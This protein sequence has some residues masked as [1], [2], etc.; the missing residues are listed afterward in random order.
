MNHNI[1]GNVCPFVYP[2]VCLSVYM[3]PLYVKLVHQ[4]AVCIHA[5][6]VFGCVFPWQTDDI[7]VE[8][9]MFIYHYTSL[10]SHTSHSSFRNGLNWFRHW[11][12]YLRRYPRIQ[13]LGCQSAFSA[14]ALLY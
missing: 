1:F 2:S 14:A 10:C 6:L 7:L 9:Q 4:S 12:E 13:N 11:L 5:V 3:L 8:A